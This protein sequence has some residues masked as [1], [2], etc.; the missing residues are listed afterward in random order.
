MLAACHAI[1]VLMRIGGD[2]AEVHGYGTWGH[3]KEYEYPPTISSSVKRL[4]VPFGRR[5]S[6]LRKT[7]TMP[8]AS[9]QLLAW[10][11]LQFRGSKDSIDSRT[12][13]AQL[14]NHS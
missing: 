9:K 6:Y 11:L 3:R 2:V 1:G 10:I 5:G 13:W 8:K 14:L 12:W 7:P 4:A